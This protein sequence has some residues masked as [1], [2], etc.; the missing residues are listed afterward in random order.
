M[1]RILII[2]RGVV[3]KYMSSPGIRCYYMAQVLRDALPDA[4]I[5]LAITNK[6]DQPV[7]PGVKVVRYGGYRILPLIA[8]NDII[9]SSSFMPHF[10]FFHGKKKFVVDLFSQY[11]VE[12]MELTRAESRGVKQAAW[13]NKNRTYLNMQLTQA[14]F[15]L[16]ANERQ[17]P[18]RSRR[19]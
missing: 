3:G 15:I 4:Q 12:W 11:F 6:E 19:L 8:N 7:I 5:T 18:H 2:A 1:K 14:D 13:M 9:I 10:A 17:R 16:C